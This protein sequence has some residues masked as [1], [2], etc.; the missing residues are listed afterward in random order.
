[1]ATP[2][3]QVMC[4]LESPDG[5]LLSTGQA[6]VDEPD[7]GE[8]LVVMALDAP[9]TVVARCLLGPVREVQVTLGDDPPCKARVERVFFH[10]RYGRACALRLLNE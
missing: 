4:R 6:M 5:Q 7:S 2:A 8:R 3:V 1:M 9:G 10:P